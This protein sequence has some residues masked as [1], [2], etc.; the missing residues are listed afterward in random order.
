M[1]SF[2]FYLGYVAERP[3]SEKY[4]FIRFSVR[5]YCTPNLFFYN[6]IL[7]IFNS[8]LLMSLSLALASKL[9]IS[10]LLE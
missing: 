1:S 9:P 2:A 3:P 6:L 5:G 4:L 10:I 7:Y 8:L